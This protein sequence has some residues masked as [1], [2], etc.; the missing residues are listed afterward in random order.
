MELKKPL[1]FAEQVKRLQVH[2][3]KVTDVTEAK[4]FL[5]SV[6]YYRFTGYALEFRCAPHKS[7][8][9]RGTSFEQVRLI[10]EFDERL[11]SILRLY[12]EK[13]EIYYRT[14]ISY[15]FSSVKC[16]TAPHDQHYN[17]KNYHNAKR[18]HELM[19]NFAK[20]ENH[21]NDSLIVQHHRRQYQNEMPLWVIV[22][23]MTF[24][25]ISLLYSCMYFSEQDCIAREIGTT[26][27]LLKNHLHCLAVFRNRCAHAG[28]LYNTTFNPPAR[29]GARF[30]KGHPEVR[31][32]TLFAY[33]LL[34]IRRQ[35][36]IQARQS[37][38]YELA[39]IFQK[40]EAVV[41]FSLLG[42]PDNYLSIMQERVSR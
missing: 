7:E 27:G 3:M 10:Y 19:E 15:G 38:V 16:Q 18:F 23:L 9:L 8:Y 40:Y 42:I 13:A 41:N 28:R 1:S 31:T 25:T 37:L 22:E 35:P 17:E 14:Q 6:N 39:E 26:R 34:L 11:R 29:F 33:C 36:S 5:A 24:S 2:G 32:D 30:L 4:R 12:L 21:Y 20:E